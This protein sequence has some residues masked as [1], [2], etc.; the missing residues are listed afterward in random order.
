MQTLELGDRMNNRCCCCP[1]C[2]PAQPLHVKQLQRRAAGQRHGT[3]EQITDTASAG[4]GARP[5]LDRLGTAVAA[6]PLPASAAVSTG[7][8][9]STALFHLA[10]SCDA[11]L[12]SD[13]AG[14]LRRRATCRRRTRID[15]VGH[16]VEAGALLHIQMH[17]SGRG[18][19]SVGGC[20]L[21]KDIFCT[22]LIHAERSPSFRC[23]PL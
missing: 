21:G 17:C 2:M 3:P 11:G 18:L 22:P 20:A 19:Q 10:T 4:M 15:R 5:H 6:S 1:L 9:V 8:S 16:L 7:F 13:S 12:C 23:Q 14:L